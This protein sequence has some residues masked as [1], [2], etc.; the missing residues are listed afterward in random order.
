MDTVVDQTAAWVEGTIAARKRLKPLADQKKLMGQGKGW[1]AAPDVLDPFQRRAFAIL[2]VIGRG[3]YNAPIDWDSIFWK[4]P[5]A[6]KVT[7]NGQSFA[8]WDSDELTRAVMLAHDA[9]IRFAIAP[10]SYTALE[11]VMTRRDRD[12]AGICGR[13]PSLTEAVITHRQRYPEG[14]PIIWTPSAG[15]AAE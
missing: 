2:G 6:L 12:T 8:T 1:W 14:H 3:I 15:M 7:W 10:H 13:K 5:G 11:I 9:G 4:M